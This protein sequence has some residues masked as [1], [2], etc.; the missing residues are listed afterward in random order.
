M[1]A[2]PTPIGTAVLESPDVMRRRHLKVVAS[3]V[4]FV[5]AV[6]VLAV[7]QGLS[8]LVYATFAAGMFLGG[9]MVMLGAARSLARWQAAHSA[10]LFRD[11]AFR[12][13]REPRSVR[14]G[15]GFMD[16]VKFFVLRDPV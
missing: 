16:G 6:G 10:T 4:V 12:W 3:Q 2:E 8:A 14:R 5:L 9:G 15:S 1:T 13:R 11:P 7:I